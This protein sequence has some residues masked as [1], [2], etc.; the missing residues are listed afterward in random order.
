MSVQRAVFRAVREGTDVAI[1]R[2]MVIHD[3]PW[4]AEIQLAGATP[5]HDIHSVSPPYRYTIQGWIP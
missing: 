4:W 3:T 5:V 2:P 1:G